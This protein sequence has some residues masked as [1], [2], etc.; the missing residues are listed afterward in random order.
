LAS[1]SSSTHA[2]SRSG[3]TIF[4]TPSTLPRIFILQKTIQTTR[5]HEQTPAN[6]AN[7]LWRAVAA[8]CWR[9]Y[10]TCTPKN[11]SYHAI[12]MSELTRADTATSRKGRHTDDAAAK[13][14]GRQQTHTCH[15]RTSQP[16]P[17]THRTLHKSARYTHCML[18]CS[19][20]AP[21]P[22]HE[23][24][25]RES[26]PHNKPG[27][28]AARTR[29]Q[30]LRQDTRISPKSEA[31]QHKTKGNKASKLTGHDTQVLGGGGDR[32]LM[33]IENIPLRLRN[34]PL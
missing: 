34:Y 27:R 18:V 4:R 10:G 15:A 22:G 6:K 13:S 31:R 17:N 14:A 21:K 19:R 5:Q 9:R 12:N 25:P 8:S 3:W 7:T 32:S 29:S 30:S 2:R 28:H 1:C 33:L 16:R 23:T 24:R 26:Q 20:T 11:C